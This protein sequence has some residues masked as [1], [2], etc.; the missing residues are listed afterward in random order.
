MLHHDADGLIGFEAVDDADNVGMF[1]A[2]HYFDFPQHILP[3]LL[4]RQ[5]ELL[6]DL[7]HNFLSVCLASA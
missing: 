5:S 7:D 3:L 1:Y 2:F 6:K 4:C